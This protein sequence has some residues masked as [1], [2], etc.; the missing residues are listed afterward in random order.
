MQICRNNHPPIVHDRP[1][2]ECPLCAV[3]DKEAKSQ[4]IISDF[5]K[6]MEAIIERSTDQDAVSACRD[7]LESI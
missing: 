1:Y 3:L 4:E 6:V 7:M 5:R 2:N